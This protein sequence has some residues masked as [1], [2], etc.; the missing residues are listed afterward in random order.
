[1]SFLASVLPALI[2]LGVLIIIHELGHFIAC[3][4]SGVKVEKFSIGFGPEIFSIKHKETQYVLSLLPLGGFVKPAGES[5]SETDASGPKKGDYLAAPLISKIAIVVAGV[6]MNYLLAFVL[7]TWIFMAGRP[8]PGTTI[9]SFV[10][11]YPAAAS[12]L[13]KGDRIM[14]VQS[15]PVKNW[16]ELT[17]ALDKAPEGAIQLEVSRAGQTQPISITPKTD[18]VKDIFGHPVKL[19]R[20]GITPDPSASDFEKYGFGESLKMA[21]ETVYFQASMTYKA[22]FYLIQGKLS[23]KTLSGPIGIITMTGSAASLGWVYLL[24]LAASLSISLAVINLL[25]VPA[26]DGGHLVFLLIEGIIRKPVSLKVQERATQ[27]GFYLLLS[28]MVF[29]IYND[30]INLEVVEKI[31]SAFVKP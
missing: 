26:L 24:Q 22:I 28:L 12:G 9:A 13:Q 10:D 17:E 31:K 3:R 18:E 8:I 21:W 19:K 15:A 14:S 5:I 11:G 23:M 27:V 29:V 16:R 20:L 2:V 4:I 25:P 6:V 1:M 7:F 30:I